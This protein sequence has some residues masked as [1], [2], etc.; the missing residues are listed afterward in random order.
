M[1]TKHRWGLLGT[2]DEKEAKIALR[3]VAARARIVD[4]SCLV[5]IE[6]HYVNLETSAIE[7]VYSFPLPLDATVTAFQ[8]READ[9]VMDGILKG[10]DEAFD[11]YDLA[12]S[13]NRSAYL[14][15]QDTANHFTCSV[16]NL[17]PGQDVVVS[18]TFAQNLERKDNHYRFYLPTVIAEVYTPLE[19]A[20]KMDPSDLERLYPPR[21]QDPLPYGLSL[22][23]EIRMA[24]SVKSV[25]SPSHTLKTELGPDCVKLSFASREVVLDKDFVVNIETGEEQF[26]TAQVYPDPCAGGWIASATFLPRLPEWAAQARNI[27]FIIDCSGSMSGASI[28]LA[29]DALQLLLSSL[30]EGDSFDIFAFGSSWRALA[31]RLTPYDETSLSQ[32]RNWV[33]S[34]DADLGGTELLGP[35][36]AALKM[37]SNKAKNIILLTDGA[38]GNNAEI[39]NKVSDLHGQ[40]RIFTIGIG[41]HTDEELLRNLAEISGGGME[42]VSPGE[43]L[44]PVVGRHL[45]RLDFPAGSAIELDWAGHKETLPL[46]RGCLLPNATAT[47]LQHFDSEPQGKVTLSLQ[48]PDKKKHILGQLE[49]V[50]GAEGE[51][52][53]PQLYAKHLL[54]TLR[55]QKKGS[56][57]HRKDDTGK[58]AE[59]ALRY[60]IL[61]AYT[62][63]V[64]VDPRTKNELPGAI[65][66]RRI[67]VAP[68]LRVMKLSSMSQSHDMDMDMICSYKINPDA[69]D[70]HQYQSRKES[71]A[72]LSGELSGSPAYLILRELVGS[73]SAAGYWE[74]GE[75]IDIMRLDLDGFDRLLKDLARTHG[76]NDETAFR[77]ALTL[78]AVFHLQH[79]NTEVRDHH[80]GLIE[81]ALVWL[82]LQGL[83]VD[84]FR[85][86]L[87]KTV[88]RI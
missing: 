64:V 52:C 54:S 80:R 34:L 14:L 23:A 20:R 35:L 51:N 61:S 70:R 28:A 13:E 5:T 38:V 15:D 21:A 76:W 58:A 43:E 12:L 11:D 57:Q 24:G 63:F 69:S 87:E 25:S 71:F 29:R 7:A 81:K 83:S 41:S 45:A 56:R 30:R 68:T 46:S 50:R 85:S 84:D 72:D 8:V 49:L 27:V 36:T 88:P 1:E 2:Q 60:R 82:G 74:K 47:F 9:L 48:T 86:A 3:G 73:Q 77:A 42:M 59:I 62:S 40:N 18:L 79:I 55:W 78:C 31:G 19:E 17:A 33:K 53:V 65:N 39:Q 4:G 16:G 44:A 67:P 37:D 32:A 22:S 75:L 6:Q 10:K 26:T 66:L